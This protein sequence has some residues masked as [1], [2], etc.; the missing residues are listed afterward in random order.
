[1]KH[2]RYTSGLGVQ[3]AD[4]IHRSSISAFIPLQRSFMEFFVNL[5]FKKVASGC[6]GQFSGFDSGQKFFFHRIDMILAS[7]LA[8]H[9]TA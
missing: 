6:F 8:K 4:L 2:G 7:P 9:L 1:M 5:P 3:F